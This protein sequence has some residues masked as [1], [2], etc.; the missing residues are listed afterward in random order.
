VAVPGTKCDEIR[1]ATLTVN[2]GGQLLVGE[3]H[4][5]VSN[6]GELYFGENSAL[7]VNGI[8]GVMIDDRSTIFVDEG[9][10]VTINEGGEVITSD[11]ASVI[12]GKGSVFNIKSGGIFRAQ[13]TQNALVIQEGGTLIIE[14]DALIELVDPSQEDG[15]A[16]I[17]IEPGGTLRIEGKF[18]LTGNGYFWLQGKYLNALEYQLPIYEDMRSDFSWQGEGKNV[19]RLFLDKFQMV[20]E[21][22]PV[23]IKDIQVDCRGIG[24]IHA[25]GSD[26]RVINARIEGVGSGNEVSGMGITTKSGSVAL[27]QNSDFVHLYRGFAVADMPSASIG[28]PYFNGCKF[29]DCNIGLMAH[30]VRQV[31]VLLSEFSQCAGTAM[32]LLGVSSFANIAG[33]S[34]TGSGA[35]E[36]EHG[37][38]LANIATSGSFLYIDPLE[39]AAGYFSAQNY[40]IYTENVTRFRMSAGTIEDCSKGVFSPADSRSNFVFSNQTLLQN[41]QVGVHIQHGFKDIVGN[42]EQYFGMVLLDCV[43]ML[44]N[45]IGILGTNVLLQIDAFSNSGTSNPIYVRA[46]HFR[47]LSNGQNILSRL[48]HVCYEAGYIPNTIFARGNYWEN[49]NNNSHDWRLLSGTEYCYTTN[50]LS[51]E[52]TLNKTFPATLAPTGCPNQIIIAGPGT[53]GPGPIPQDPDGCQPPPGDELEEK[54]GTQFYH[55][56]KMFSDEAD[57]MGDFSGSDTLFQ[58]V[59]NLKDEDVALLEEKC[60]KYVATSRAFVRA[61]LTG[62][63]DKPEERNLLISNLNGILVQPNPANSE[64]II[65]VA[66][67]EDNTLRVWNAQGRLMHE[68]LNMNG[69]ARLDISKW[70]GGI[71]LIDI[72][73]QNLRT[74]R[75]F[76][77]QH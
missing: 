44:D 70:P 2:P 4:D 73:G 5:N 47:R 65:K 76:I 8:E 62:K 64:V 41:N 72:N 77:V 43:G 56:Y 9:A 32:A 66:T 51:P 1:E 12:V 52:I 31:N 13:S 60:Q 25:I 34:I 75:K 22:K 7:V 48:F 11:Y 68:M 37:G 6:I 35:E 27:V 33:V 15:G 42:T 36:I 16:C 63:P 18:K 71:Y 57:G 40:G 67:F 28:F 61:D 20:T 30:N 69:Q 54:L 29:E 21:G 45:R 10:A 49:L 46:N 50:V 19:R 59:A 23:F 55:G 74:N 53:P 17:K 26:V 39:E 58:K 14:Q 3:F 24:G 38:M